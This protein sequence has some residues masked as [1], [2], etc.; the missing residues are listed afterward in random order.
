MSYSTSNRGVVC[1]RVNPGLPS[2]PPQLVWS[3]RNGR[4]ESNSP[5]RTLH[6]ANP[7][8]K[9]GSKKVFTWKQN[10]RM[11][12]FINNNLIVVNISTLR[13]FLCVVVVQLFM[14]LQYSHHKQPFSPLQVPLSG[15]W[16]R[17]PTSWTRRASGPERHQPG[18]R[19]PSSCS[20]RQRGRSAC[21]RP[22]GAS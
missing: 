4:T 2:C 11:C 22:Q 21:G 13:F 14:S 1:I 5:V 16:R 9:P 19:Y 6:T 10:S 15:A 7:P 3:S 18:T 8:R 20:S 17:W 12:A